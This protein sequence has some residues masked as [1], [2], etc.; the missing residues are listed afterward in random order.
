MD[1]KP[2]YMSKGVWGSVI[3]VLVT[4]L[5]LLGR[6]EEADIVNEQSGAISETII[7]LVTIAAGALALWGRL[8]A[9]SKVTT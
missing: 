6:K 2:F 8:S 9:K 5:T 1:E 7:Q 4:V 3:V